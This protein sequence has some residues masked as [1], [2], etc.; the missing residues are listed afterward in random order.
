MKPVFG[1]KCLSP[2]VHFRDYCER[3]SPHHT[4]P[5][6]TS[7]PFS[8]VVHHIG[9]FVYEAASC[10]LCRVQQQ[11]A[12]HAQALA[13][14]TTS[15]HPTIRKNSLPPPVNP[16]HALLCRW[17]MQWW[18]SASME[19]ASLPATWQLPCQ[20]WCSSTQP[21]TRLWSPT[22]SH[23]SGDEQLTCLS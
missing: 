9:Q 5:G 11:E 16:T 2:H 20:R 14:D 23:T 21:S 19:A 15:P 4:P 13:R 3:G 18:T 22:D 8:P 17:W 7:H 6:R 1:M 10:L 12:L